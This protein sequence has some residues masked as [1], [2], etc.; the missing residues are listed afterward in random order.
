MTLVTGV[1]KGDGVC[2]TDLHDMWSV[3]TPPSK[4]PAMEANPHIAPK[5]PKTMGLFCNGREYAIM[6]SAPEKIP[7]TPIPAI[8]LPTMSAVL[9]GAT[10]HIKEPSSKTPMAHK[11]IVFTYSSRQPRT[12][13]I[14]KEA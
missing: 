1:G 10:P 12:M 8:A 7:P 5:N 14:P 3:K 13:S 2:G 9:E 4:G 6:T 11:K